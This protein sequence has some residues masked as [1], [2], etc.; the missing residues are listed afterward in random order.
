MKSWFRRFNIY[1]ALAGVFLSPGCASNKSAKDD[2]KKEQ[3]TIRLYMEGNRVDTASTGT[4]LI[5]REKLP[6]TIEREPFLTEADLSK[7]TMIDD[8]GP[9]PSYAIQLLF[10]AHGTLFLDMSTIANKGRH[11]IVFS[12]FPIPGTKSPKAKRQ[13]HASDD[14]EIEPM[15]EPLPPPESTATNQPRQS[16]WLAAVLIRD[17]NS[18][19]I[20]RF[21]PDASHE[22]GARIVR[23]LK[24]VIAAR[25]KREKF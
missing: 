20:F 2:A 21:T 16:A 17:R 25:K 13:K 5:T 11:I 8:P 15:N 9:N 12:Q 22:E 19:G 23:G 10:D 18:S 4:A 6:F 24:N 14:D 1:F 3:S 7:V